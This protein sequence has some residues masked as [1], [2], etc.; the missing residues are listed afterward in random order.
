METCK[1]ITLANQKGG[2]AK[3]T[4]VINLGHALVNTGSR[5]L[6]VD[7]DPQA[8][9]SMSCGI[10]QPDEV[11]A[12]MH[13]LISA[14]LEGEPVDMSAYI[15]KGE[16]VDIIPSN[17][18]LSASEINLRDEMGGEQTLR[19]LLEPLKQEYDYIL[20]DTNPYLGLL[21]INALAACDE[22]IIPVNP[23]LWAAT[24]LTDLLQ[25]I[26]KVKRKINP[27]IL[28][29]GILLTICDERTRLFKDVK[30]LLDETYGDTVKIFDTYIPNTVR[31]GEANYMSRPVIEYDPTGKAAVAYNK[32]AQEVLYG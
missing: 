31:I 4:T 32:F 14:V 9:L 28:V 12:S 20:I 3:S 21:T 26:A 27:K 18:N 24:G 10:E 15:H 13:E 19:E 6:L 8:N 5:V 7:F 16:K 29:R 1:I 2:T 23:Q 11:G 17:T 30:T 25:T 22:V